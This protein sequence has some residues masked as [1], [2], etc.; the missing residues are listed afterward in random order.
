MNLLASA[1]D[2]PFIIPVGVV[3]AVMA[4]WFG[5]SAVTQW[6]KAREAAYNARLKQLM[7]ERG[8]SAD[9]IERVLSAG[10]AEESEEE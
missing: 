9:E 1:F 4:A 10:G 2:S 3:G 8:M 6:R 7:I 5:V